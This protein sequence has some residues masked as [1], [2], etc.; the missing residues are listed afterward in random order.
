MRVRKSSIV[1]VDVEMIGSADV[2]MDTSSQRRHT[3]A[4]AAFMLH[5]NGGGEIEP[6]VI[7]RVRIW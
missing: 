3:S 7:N 5:V 1:V 2:S 4:G 6:R